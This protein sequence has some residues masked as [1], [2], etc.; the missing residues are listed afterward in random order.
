MTIPIQVHSTRQTF[1]LELQITGCCRIP[2][3]AVVWSDWT[4]R[5]RRKLGNK[6]VRIEPGLHVLWSLKLLTF[7]LLS[8]ETKW[9]LC[10]EYNCLNARGC[11]SFSLSWLKA[12]C[13]GGGAWLRQQMAY[14]SAAPLINALTWLKGW[15]SRNP[16]HEQLHTGGIIIFERRSL[17]CAPIL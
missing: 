3:P 4:T 16:V 2:L 11:P 7:R 17:A 12:M 14:W 9:S 1:Q 13:D 15:V 5:V 6:R 8:S 10:S